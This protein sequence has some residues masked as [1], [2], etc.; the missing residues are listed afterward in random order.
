M[1]FISSQNDKLVIH[2]S[3]GFE[4]GEA[5]NIKIVRDFMERRRAMPALKDQLH[6][7]WLC[8]EIP[9]A[10]GRLLETGTEDFLES[11]RSG[12]LGDVPIIAVFTK[13]DMLIDRMERTLDE[14]SINGLSNKAIEEL[15]KN[16]ADAE[17]ED[18]CIGPLKQFAGPDIPYATTSTAID[19]EETL[20]HLIQITEN[21]VDQYFVP[22]AAVITSIAQ[23]IQPGLKMKAS[24]EVGKRRYWKT[25]SLGTIFMK[26]KMR[27]CLYVLHTD[28]V[29]V[30]D[31]NDPHHYLLSA[32]FRELMIKWSKL[33]LQKDID[34]SLSATRRSSASC[35]TSST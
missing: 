34:A 13:Y 30:W 14:T 8:F 26:H 20:M 28:I 11:K 32:E 19:Y 1:E 10:G 18:T 3:K 23:R 5:D 12:M 9:C 27:D 22:Q 29:D 25:L 31:F 15:A 4:P 7:V 21:C 35:P 2:D 17:L 24:I 6:A 33:D 16:K